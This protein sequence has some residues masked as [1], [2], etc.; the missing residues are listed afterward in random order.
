MPAWLK[1]QSQQSDNQIHVEQHLRKLLDDLNT[2]LATHLAQLDPLFSLGTANDGGVCTLVGV[3][4]N[5]V[6]ADVAES[7]ARQIGDAVAQL[8]LNDDVQIDSERA[9]REAMRDA[10]QSLAND[11][12][13]TFFQYYIGSWWDNSTTT[14][15][16]GGASF[17][18]AQR[19]L[20]HNS[21][22]KWKKYL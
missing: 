9:L 15:Q 6:T 20:A 12:S 2:R 18:L 21:S 7:R 16:G 1:T 19:K 4:T 17:D 14:Q 10:E 13:K 5:K 22:S 11:N 8:K 3:D